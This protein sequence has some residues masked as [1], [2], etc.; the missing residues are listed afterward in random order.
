MLG[1]LLIHSSLLLK[2][3]VDLFL[4]VFI[5]L[6][7]IKTPNSISL[8]IFKET[9]KNIKL[10]WRYFGY[11]TCLNAKYKFTLNGSPL[12]LI[13]LIHVNAFNFL[14]FIVCASKHKYII[15]KSE[16]HWRDDFLRKWRNQFPFILMDGIPFA[17]V[18]KNKLSFSV[19]SGSSKTEYVL[20]IAL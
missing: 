4:V 20:R 2:D 11:G 8:S 6:I 15:I 12:I 13:L 19:R 7:K 17:C 18:K 10:I 3:T 1:L 5:F 14:F 9:S 16:T